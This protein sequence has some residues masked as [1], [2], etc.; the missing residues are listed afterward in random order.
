MKVHLKSV[1]GMAVENGLIEG[2]QHITANTF[3]GDANEAV[4]ALFDY[5]WEH[6]DQVIDLRDES[7]EVPKGSIGFNA[8][9]VAQKRGVPQVDLYGEET[10]EQP[11]SHHK[12]LAPRRYFRQNH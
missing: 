8:T 1:V 6:L 3:K 12:Q 11:D 9:A 7:A 4:N 10:P 2:Y 5:V